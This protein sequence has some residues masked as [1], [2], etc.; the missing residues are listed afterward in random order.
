MHNMFFSKSD[1][2]HP[3]LAKVWAFEIPEDSTVAMKISHVVWWV[4]I[5]LELRAEI[6]VCFLTKYAC[7]ET[8]FF[9]KKK[10]PSI[11]NKWSKSCEIVS[12]N[13]QALKHFSS[14]LF[15]FE[16]KLLLIVNWLKWDEAGVWLAGI[17]HAK[18]TTDETSQ[19]LVIK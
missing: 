19:N 6:V 7:R 14:K 16:H 9:K 15:V 8:C 3:A 1:L 13:C 10:C 4:A 12:N 2:H 18:C 5:E 11:A 17:G